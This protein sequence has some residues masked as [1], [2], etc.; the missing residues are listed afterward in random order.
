[1]FALMERNAKE[2]LRDAMVLLF[3]VALPV[4]LLGMMAVINGASAVAVPQFQPASF[5]P[6]MAVLSQAFMMLFAGLLLAKD[7]EGA[8]LY[9]VFASPLR[10]ADYLLAYVLPLL[11]VAMVQGGVCMLAGLAFGLAPSWTLLAAWAALLPTAVMF[12]ALGLLVGC[13]LN[14]KQVGGICGGFGVTAVGMLGGIWLDLRMFS[15]AV[16]KVLRALPF[17]HAVESVRAAAAGEGAKM[18]AELVWTVL[19]AAALLGL[20][21]VVFIRRKRAG[22]LTA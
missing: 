16:Q 15:T 7:R 9:R 11:A 12:I 3:G 20:A 22:K 1:M 6:A 14:E 19:W 21:W 5:V 13:V 10:G 17:S 18:A 2:M 8:F 4:A